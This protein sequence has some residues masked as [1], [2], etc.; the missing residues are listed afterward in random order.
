M[1]GLPCACCRCLKLMLRQ[2]R[3]LARCY[4]ATA[5]AALGLRPALRGGFI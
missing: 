2:L 5:L 1:R 3:S 4:L